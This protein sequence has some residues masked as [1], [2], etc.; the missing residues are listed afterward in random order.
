MN[1]DLEYTCRPISE[2]TG[3][4]EA[5]VSK[6]ALCFALVEAATGV[7][8]EKGHDLE[9]K[10]VAGKVLIMPTGKG[11]S[12]VQADGLYRLIIHET[13]PAAVIIEQP[14]PVLVSTIIAM[15]VPLVD[16]VEPAFYE[17]VAAGDHIV[18]DAV[19]GKLVVRKTG[20]G[21]SGVNP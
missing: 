13:A 18:V 14:E 10:S 6:D 4:G 11:S 3:E 8:L 17:A 9:G 5:L 2:G 21:Q 20:A 12:V 15:E 1:P 7:V 16:T 19:G